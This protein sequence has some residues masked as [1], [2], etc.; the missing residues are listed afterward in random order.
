M[1]LFCCLRCYPDMTMTHDEASG[2]KMSLGPLPLPPP[3]G[4][5]PVN[6]LTHLL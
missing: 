4:G 6:Y 2:T 3:A 5:L 1:N